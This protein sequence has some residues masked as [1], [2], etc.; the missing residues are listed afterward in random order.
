MDHEHS[1]RI[2][3]IRIN[4]RAGYTFTRAPFNLLLKA[5]REVPASLSV[6]D[7]WQGCVA[8][9]GDGQGSHHVFDFGKLGHDG[10]RHRLGRKLITSPKPFS[11]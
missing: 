2:R 7:P 3:C 4:C 1:C 11:L 6:L 10:G 5:A 9:N 8:R